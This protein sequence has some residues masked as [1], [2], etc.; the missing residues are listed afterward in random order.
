MKLHLLLLPI[1]LAACTPTHQQPLAD[2][3]ESTAPS[4][5][6]N[7]AR[8]TDTVAVL[9]QYHW[10]L[11]DASDVQGQRIDSLFVRDGQPVQLDFI[12][13]QIMISNTCNGMSGG[14]SVVDGQLQI[15]PMAQTLM[16]CVDPSLAA[17]DTAVGDRLQGN[18]QIDLDSAGSPPRLEL[19]TVD[20]DTLSFAGQ[21]TAET[22]YGGKGKQV[23]LEV[24]A[25]SAPCDHPLIPDKS[26]LQ[27]RERSYDDN[28][29]VNGAPGEW[30]SLHQDIEGYTHQPGVRNVLRLKQFTIA[31]PPADAPSLAYVLDMVVESEQ[32][33]P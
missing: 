20:G 33:A 32:V 5:V 6:D 23:F 4:A 8:A 7:S 15:A 30:R 21:P 9:G 29:V 25:Q 22:R 13:G 26:C 19:V 24:A 14:F 2:T 11:T 28:G 18:A 10:Q 27:V 12:D 17:L 1:A 16:A 3:S 31:H